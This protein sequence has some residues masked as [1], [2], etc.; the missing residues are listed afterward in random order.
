MIK[1]ENQKSITKTK[2]TDKNTKNTTNNNEHIHNDIKENNK[3][4]KIRDR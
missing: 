2:N 3:G 4:E 1:K